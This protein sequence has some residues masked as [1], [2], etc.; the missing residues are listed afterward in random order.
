MLF[1]L[2]LVQELAEPAESRI[3]TKRPLYKVFTGVSNCLDLHLG[4]SQGVQSRPSMYFLNQR[5][6]STR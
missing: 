4:T 1:S 6:S 2:Q 3:N 5:I